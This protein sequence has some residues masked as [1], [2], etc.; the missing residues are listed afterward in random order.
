MPLFATRGPE[1]RLD[2]SD[3][4]FVD[5]VHSNAFV[6][7]MAQECGHSD[8]YMNGGLMQPGCSSELSESPTSIL[9]SH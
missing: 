1:G 3:A 9:S 6:Q 2:A 4:R 5:V 7:G 8:F